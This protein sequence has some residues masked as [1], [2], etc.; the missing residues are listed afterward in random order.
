MPAELY[1]D[2]CTIEYEI[3]RTRN[4]HP[5]A[6]VFVVD[7]CLREDELILCRT[8]LTQALQSLPEYAYVGLVTFGT[9]VH[10]HELGFAEFSKAYVFQ[11]SVPHGVQKRVMFSF[12]RHKCCL[13]GKVTCTARTVAAI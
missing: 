7:T 2:Y 9:H 8:S 5:P 12:G 4:V 10:V 1:A 13:S 11:V 6:Y 3:A